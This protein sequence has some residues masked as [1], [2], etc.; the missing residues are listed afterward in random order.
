MERALMLI[1]RAAYLRA[2]VCTCVCVC[3][4]VCV[5]VLLSNV[6]FLCTSLRIA[7][8]QRDRQKYVS[9]LYHR[10]MSDV[11]RYTPSFSIICA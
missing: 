5:C 6:F 3:M 10:L 9:N 1:V 7:A 11:L 8:D 4:C 2:C